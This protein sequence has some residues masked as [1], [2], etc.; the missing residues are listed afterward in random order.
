M[1]T[2]KIIGLE[3]LARWQHPERGFIPP[4]KFIAVAERL[5]LITLLTESMIKQVAN[6]LPAFTDIDP[7]LKIAINISGSECSN[8]HILHLIQD[9]IKEKNINPKQIELEVTES[10]LIEHPESSIKILTTLSNLGISIAIDDF[11]TGYS[12]L[13][14]LTDLPIDILK[15]DRSFVEGIGVNP[16]QEIVIQVII[17]LAKRLSLKVIAEGV[18]TPAQAEFLAENGCDYGQGY[19]YS[20]PLPAQAI[21]K[22]WN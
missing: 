18:E 7:E 13:S 4:S 12:S 20:K 11:G 16:Q 22:L 1:Q 3:A 10:I 5:S 8:P 14:Y 15:I 6:Y 19:F 21:A 17:D 9:L 2:Q